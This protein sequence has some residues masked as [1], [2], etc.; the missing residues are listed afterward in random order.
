MSSSQELGVQSA[1]FFGSRSGFAN[2]LIL[3]IFLY[4]KFD[5]IVFLY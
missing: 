1:C 3:A 2:W 5:K 4:I